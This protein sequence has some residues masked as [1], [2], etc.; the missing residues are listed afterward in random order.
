M[1]HHTQMWTNHNGGLQVSG[2]PRPTT[3]TTGSGV[4][5]TDTGPL[6]RPVA[7]ERALPFGCHGSK[8]SF[9]VLLELWIVLGIG[10]LLPEEL[11][12]ERLL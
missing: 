5:N 4:G 9:Q 7:R 11:L 12:A 3:T 2:S 10:K 8:G 1:F 6:F